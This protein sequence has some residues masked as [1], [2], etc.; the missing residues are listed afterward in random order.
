MGNE[1]R[2]APRVRVNLPAKWEGALHQE[3]A[4]IT[5]LSISGCFVL[6]GGSVEVK[7]LIWLEIQLP[8]GPVQYWA[9][10]VDAAYEIGFAVRFNSSSSDD[11]EKLLASYIEGV[12]ATDS[13]RQL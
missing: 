7:E 11:D 8:T 6:S 9:E 12:L 13:S 4:A 5:D 2:R 1:R 3:A 10:V